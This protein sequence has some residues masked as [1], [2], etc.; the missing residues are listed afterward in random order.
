MRDSLSSIGGKNST[1]IR[2]QTHFVR[3]RFGGSFNGLLSTIPYFW[4]W[5]SFPIFADWPP[6]IVFA[7]LLAF[8]MTLLTVHSQLPRGVI[9]LAAIWVAGVAVA[10]LSSGE[11]GSLESLQAL[12]RPVVV[13]ALICG[14]LAIESRKPGSAEWLCVS[15]ICI[16][17][18]GTLLHADTFQL[19]GIDAAWKYVIG[20]PVTV[21]ILY[22]VHARQGGR[23][24]FVVAGV[25]LAALS[26][27]LGSRSLALTTLIGVFLSANANSWRAQTPGSVGRCCIGS[28]HTSECLWT[29]C[30]GWKFW[31]RTAE[32]METAVVSASWTVDRW[33]T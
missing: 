25:A 30:L 19:A 21:L 12:T 1:V 18:I 4:I 28:G 7:L 22:L 5:L 20:W 23:R 27:V 13:V 33:T 24:W 17:G 11:F 6:P 3:L 8:P 32:Q 2:N 10:D 29:G 9:G 31:H 15:F 16:L 26:L 14:V